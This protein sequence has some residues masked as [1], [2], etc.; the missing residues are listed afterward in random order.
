MQLKQDF[1][2]FE[3]K[4]KIEEK[5]DVQFKSSPVKKATFGKSLSQELGESVLAE[6]EYLELDEEKLDK[7]QK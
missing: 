7:V 4:Y 6:E 1:D 3:D 5:K 2:A